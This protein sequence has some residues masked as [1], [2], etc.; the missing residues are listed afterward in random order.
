MSRLEL[1]EFDEML[2]Q[3]RAEK[4]ESIRFAQ[5]G[6]GVHDGEMVSAD[7]PRLAE[8]AKALREQENSE[9]TA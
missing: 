4:A 8:W 1:P 9:V 6:L 7:D 5:A 2:E 3:R